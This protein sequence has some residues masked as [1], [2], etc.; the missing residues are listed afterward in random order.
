M[1][2]TTLVFSDFLKVSIK[3]LTVSHLVV[4]VSNTA[5]HVE[6]AR[7]VDH[8]K[9]VIVCLGCH[10][11]SEGSIYLNQ[12]SQAQSTERFLMRGEI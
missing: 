4:Q 1:L 9:S 6:L 11:D 8:W 10:Q 3:S 2:F 5:K 12:L 7:Q